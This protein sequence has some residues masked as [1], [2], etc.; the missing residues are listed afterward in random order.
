MNVELEVALI[1]GAVSLVV[2]VVT[3]VLT[4]VSSERALKRQYQLEF[5]AERVVR[6][7]LSDSVWP[8]RSFDII[9]RHLGGFEND[10][11]RKILVRAGAIRFKLTSGDEV[12]GLL[13]RNAAREGQDPLD[14]SLQTR[15]AD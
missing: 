11:L 4:T 1:A 7:I 10:E 5:A 14:L 15:P 12:W 8:L 3:S 9:K 13:E 2:A 6:K